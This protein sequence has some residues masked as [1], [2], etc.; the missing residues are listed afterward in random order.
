MAVSVSTQQLLALFLRVP[1]S[2]MFVCIADG[3]PSLPTPFIVI[4]MHSFLAMR[5]LKWVRPACANAKEEVA[6]FKVSTT[7]VGQTFL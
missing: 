1:L 2:V 3:S 7:H 4:I 6:N 5:I